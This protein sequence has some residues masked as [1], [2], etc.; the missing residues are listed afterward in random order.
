MA[1]HFL[2]GILFGGL[3]LDTNTEGRIRSLSNEDLFFLEDDG[4]VEKIPLVADA[5]PIPENFWLEKVWRVDGQLYGI[6]AYQYFG[7]LPRVA[8]AGLCTIDDD[9]VVSPL[10][11]PFFRCDDEIDPG[12]CLNPGSLVLGGWDPQNEWFQVDIYQGTFDLV[13]EVDRTGTVLGEWSFDRY[14]AE[15]LAHWQR[16]T[17]PPEASVHALTSIPLNDSVWSAVYY[18]SS[19][20]HLFNEPG[21]EIA[22]IP[23]LDEPPSPE[24]QLLFVTQYTASDGTLW[25]AAAVGDDLVIRRWDTSEGDLTEAAKSSCIFRYCLP[26][27]S[28]SAAAVTAPLRTD[29]SS[30][31]AACASTAARIQ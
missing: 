31:P 30:C 7:P 6:W 20:W 5:S 15:D 1:G 19:S 3:Y 2:G 22:Q 17:L 28:T 4:T 9:G 29:R 26:E 14:D 21:A 16:L 25:V 8:T 24:R 23:L 12:Y 27:T 11:E 13:Y 18:S 10:G